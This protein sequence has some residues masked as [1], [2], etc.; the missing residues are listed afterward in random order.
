MKLSAVMIVKNEAHQIGE[1]LD[2]LRFA[3]ETVVLDGGSTDRTA[4]VSA[5]HGA[6]V[7]SRAF[8][9]FSSQRN[10]AASLAVGDWILMIDADERVSEAL[11]AEIRRTIEAPSVDAYRILRRTR[12]F[13]R[14][15]RF[16]GL[17]NDRPVR[18]FRRGTAE[19]KGEVHEVLEPHGPVGDLKE[20]LTH[21]SF[22]I[23]SEHRRRLEQYTNLEA[24]RAGARQVGF[25]DLWLRPAGRFVRIYFGQ[26]G[27]RDGFEGFAF[28]AL[29][30]YY[31]F[32]RWAKTWELNH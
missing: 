6:K 21:L 11:A 9:D 10:H 1:C 16:S 17:Q 32:V 13:S 19:F 27:F 14:V 31:E 5:E 2:A 29:S 20:P 15:F 26:Q 12:L 23:V 18:L 4:A 22:Q 7:F 28:A 30:A 24:R 3:D 8:D 25:G